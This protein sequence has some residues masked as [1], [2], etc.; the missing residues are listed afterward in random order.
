MAIEQKF[1][2]EEATLIIQSFIKSYCEKAGVTSVTI[3]LSGGIDSAVAAV[4]CAQVLGH[5]NTECLFLP[6]ESTPMEDKRDVD[7]FIKQFDIPCITQDIS[8]LIESVRKQ[9]P[10]EPDKM[11]LANIKARIRMT[12][13][14]SHAN[15]HHNL[16]CGTS[17][18]SELLIG[19]FTK[20][21]DGGVDFMPLGDVYKTQIFDLARYLDL[22]KPMITKPPSA[23]LWK[24]QTDEKELNMSY[25]LLDQILIGLERKLKSNMIAKQVGI[26]VDEVERIHE[27]RICSQHKRNTAL[28]PKIGLRTPGLDWRS[29]VLKG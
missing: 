10:I 23:G 5:K 22:P 18:K 14:F 20:Y 13:L 6:D 25:E 2:V 29:P 7:L 21:G 12:L 1:D 17:N 27:M 4:L 9:C 19:Y 15:M 3:G 11:A 16:V 26:S 28:I 8:L 24:G